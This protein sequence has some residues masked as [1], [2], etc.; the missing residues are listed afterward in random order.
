M[1]CTLLKKPNKHEMIEINKLQ[2]ERKRKKTKKKTMV[3][4]NKS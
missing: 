1:D 2:Y 3:T 4:V